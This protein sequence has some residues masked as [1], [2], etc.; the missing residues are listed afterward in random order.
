MMQPTNR[1]TQRYSRNVNQESHIKELVEYIAL[2]LVDDP[3]QVV[4]TEY[5]SGGRENLELHVAREDMGRVIGKGGKIANAIRVLLRVAAAREG[6]QVN[7]DV[8][9]PR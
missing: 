8:A 4:V 9:E 5:R 6:K 3:S 7:L 2:S 1:P